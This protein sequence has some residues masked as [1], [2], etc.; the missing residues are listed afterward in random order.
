MKY[1][2]LIVEKRDDGIAIVTLNRPERL[3]AIT[4]IMAEELFTS[5]DDICQDDYVRAVIITGAGRGFCS[6]TDISALQ[7]LASVDA[8]GEFGKDRHDVR[9][10]T[11]KWVIP[12]S[13]LEKPTIAA[14]NGVA[15]G[16]GFSLCL[17]CD[18]R[19]ASESAKF[20]A[21]WVK[22]G[23]I[24]EAGSTYH[25]PRIIG[26]SRTYELVL[27]GKTIDAREAE[28]IGIVNRIVPN[29]ELLET[30]IELAVQI[31]SGPPIT[32]ELAKKAIARGAESDL[33]TALFSE[34]RAQAICH[35]T[36]DH[37]E[38]IR[39]FLEKRPPVFKGK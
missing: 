11:P 14:I 27:T 31:A 32:I 7:D 30:A 9:G 19:I 29:D 23:L 21:V 15:A 34:N 37:E 38:G 17:A 1:N 3:N 33:G 36:E 24:C 20:A 10:P 12:L 18:I 39:A 25:L 28:R 16:A 26:T 8:Y 22:R 5:L 13:T 35:M 4:Q 2:T 6:G